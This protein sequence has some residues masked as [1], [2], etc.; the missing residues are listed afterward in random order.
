[1]NPLT[2]T[3]HIIH[4]LKKII[5]CTYTTTL[6]PSPPVSSHTTTSTIIHIQYVTHIILPPSP[7]P[8]SLSLS[9]SLS[10][11]IIIIINY[12]N[13]IT[14][15]FDIITI[16]CI[17]III[18]IITISNVRHIKKH[19]QTCL[20]V[21]KRKRECVLLP[22]MH[23]P[24]SLKRNTTHKYTHKYTKHTQSIQHQRRGFLKVSFSL[25]RKAIVEIGSVVLA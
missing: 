15:L 5:M 9:L 2:S 19:M 12:Y 18:K 4:K 10:I 3:R 1:M 7:P 13:E 20:S 17:I 8:P 25:R 23:K 24:N 22:T 6:L 21:N 14:L 11:I 16:T